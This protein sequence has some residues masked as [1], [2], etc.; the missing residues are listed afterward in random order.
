M[1]VGFT[2]LAAPGQADALASLLDTPEGAR[3]VARAMGASRNMLFRQGDRFV[4]VF[5]FT[6]GAKP[7]P[8]AEVAQ[9]DPVIKDFLRRIGKLT[10]PAYDP[11]DAP[12]MAAF[13][14]QASMQLVV[15]VEA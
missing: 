7:V 9:K 3:R 8:L 10:Q 12:S 15:D 4:R 2:F 1:L 11:D 13:M 5:V 6:D 14:Q